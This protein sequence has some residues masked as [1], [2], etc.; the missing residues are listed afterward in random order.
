MTVVE[1]ERR[2]AAA[3]ERV[4]GVYTDHEGWSRWAGFG[5]VRLVREG[6]PDRNGVG[7]ARAFDKAPG[8]VEEVTA[9]EAPTRLGY[10]IAA[11]GGPLGDHAGE[12]RFEPVAGGTRL[13]WR[14]EFRSKIPGA[15]PLIALGV[16]AVFA[17][18]LDGLERELARG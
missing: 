17:R 1:V 9:F 4:F 15:G 2:F 14:V 6:S 12:V 5:R 10:R 3:P 11:G 18:M 16:R 13:A 7:A 8:L